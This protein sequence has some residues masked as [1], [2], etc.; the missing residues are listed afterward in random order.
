MNEVAVQ[1][2][3]DARYDGRRDEAVKLGTF[4]SQEGENKG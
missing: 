4:G 2:L 1:L 3:Q